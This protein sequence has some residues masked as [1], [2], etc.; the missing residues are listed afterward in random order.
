MFKYL[1]SIEGNNS[2]E[3]NLSYGAQQVMSFLINILMV[4]SLPV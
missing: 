4:Y 3:E 1:T 2:Q